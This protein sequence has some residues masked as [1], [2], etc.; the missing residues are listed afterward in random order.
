[1]K[2]IY[3]YTQ[4]DC[5]KCDNLKRDYDRQGISYIERSANRFKKPPIDRD[6]I[7]IDAFVQ[8]SM[9]NMV[10]PVEIRVNTDERL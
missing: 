2:Y 10:L 4:P 1:M 7:D 6:D 5:S 9:Q 8:L 3:I